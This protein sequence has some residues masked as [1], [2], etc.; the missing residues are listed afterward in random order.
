MPWFYP[1][2]IEDIKQHPNS[3]NITGSKHSHY[4]LTNWT[5][6]ELSFV[7]TVIILGRN[8][9][10]ERENIL[11]EGE[12]R[13]SHNK[14]DIKTRPEETGRT[15]RSPTCRSGSTG[16]KYKQLVWAWHPWGQWQAG[17]GNTSGR[18]GT[19]TLCN[20]FPFQRT[21]TIGGLKGLGSSPV[22]WKKDHLFHDNCPRLLASISPSGQILR[23][24]KIWLC[25][26]LIKFLH[27]ELL[28]DLQSEKDVNLLEWIQKSP[29]W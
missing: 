11:I 8:K 23:A 14:S 26:E 22:A 5:H 28:G 29:T 19:R 13:S 3:V 18:W 16:Q 6:L 25:E 20:C 4:K 21:Q 27:L 1:N 7:K 10:T 12:D 17:T 2:L 15:D 24:F 9:T